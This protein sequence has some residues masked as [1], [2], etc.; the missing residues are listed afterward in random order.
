MADDVDDRNAHWRS[1]LSHPTDTGHFQP[2]STAVSLEVAGSTMCGKLQPQNTDHYLA[3][4]LGRMQETITTSLATAD[5]PPRFEEYGYALLIADGLGNRG[6]GA[7]ASR[8]ALSALADLA[9]RYGKWNV[10]VDPASTITI[11]EQGRFLWQRTHE[12]VVRASRSNEQLADM[13]TSLTAAYVAGSDMFFAHVGHSRAY[14]FRDGTLMKLTIDHTLTEQRSGRAGP[15]LEHAKKDFAHD[16]TQFVGGPQDPQVQVEH[17][18]LSNADR[19]LLCSNGLTD[20]VSENEIAGTLA[21]QRRPADDCE[22]LLDLATEAHA[23]DDVTVLV[24]DYR[25][26]V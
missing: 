20:T 17:I 24:A 19:L 7:R 6:S 4:R 18:R 16:V 2:L 10:R 3:I 12:A 22:R 9:I 1:V 5:L 25:V 21:L 14:L 13:A 26:Q 8:I 11:L 15:G 23:A